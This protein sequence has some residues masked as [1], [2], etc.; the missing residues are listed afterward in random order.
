MQP[1]LYSLAIWIDSVFSP[2][3][4]YSFYVQTKGNILKTSFPI[5]YLIFSTRNGNLRLYASDN[6]YSEEKKKYFH[7]NEEIY[8]QRKSS[9]FSL[10]FLSWKI[11]KMHLI[12][13]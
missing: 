3:K 9:K 13:Q 2:K 7:G 12:T 11:E 8:I 6:G 10:F 4:N 5:I 1:I